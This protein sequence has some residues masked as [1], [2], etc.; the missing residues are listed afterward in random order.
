MPTFRVDTHMTFFV[1][2][3]VIAETEADARAIIEQGHGVDSEVFQQYLGEQ[4]VK[5][6]SVGHKDALT[7]TEELPEGEQTVDTPSS[8]ATSS[9]LDVAW[10]SPD[11]LDYTTVMSVCQRMV[12]PDAIRSLSAVESPDYVNGYED[13]V[14]TVCQL[15]TDVRSPRLTT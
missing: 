15:L 1:S 5:V 10:E 12:H 7:T 13:A 14:D 6:H 3:C 2:Y 9:A 4:I 8:D 11:A